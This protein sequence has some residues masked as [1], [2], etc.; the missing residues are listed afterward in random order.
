MSG[1]G[2]RDGRAGGSKQGGEDGL[3]R[4]ALLLEYDGSRYG[5]SQIQKNAPTIEGELE[6][7][8]NKL[9]GERHRVAFAGRTD[10]GVHACGQVASFLTPAHYETEVFRRGLNHW[11]PEDIAVKRAL[12]T[13]LGFDPRRQARRRL[14][15][16]LVYNSP[17]PSPLLR[18]RAWHVADALDSASMA[19]AMACLIGKRDFA[20]FGAALS[21]PRASTVRTVYRAEVLRKG[22]LIAFSMEADA[23]LPHQV[24]RTVGALVEVGLMRRTREWFEAML[25]QPETGAAGPA[26]PPQ[27]LYLVRV[28]YRDV[29]ISDETENEDI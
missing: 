7:A 11:L 3:R 5:G 19:Q 21:R 4:I 13:P 16:Y 26:A 10:A 1:A 29:K 18:Q 23:F 8:L 28:T 15:R 9:T 20:S 6:E 12:E 27:G 14:Y 24:R 17:S 22:E 2:E 25:R